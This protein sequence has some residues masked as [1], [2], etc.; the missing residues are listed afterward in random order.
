[1]NANQ[2]NRY[3]LIKNELLAMAEDEPLGGCYR[4]HKERIKELEDEF[5]SLTDQVSRPVPKWSDFLEYITKYKPSRIDLGVINPDGHDLTIFIPGW[6][7]T[8]SDDGSWKLDFDC[9]GT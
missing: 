7:V 8:I 6:A 1:M 3:L 2:R 5:L 9:D 4:S